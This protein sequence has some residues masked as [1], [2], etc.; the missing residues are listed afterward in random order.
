MKNRE[1]RQIIEETQKN[2]FVVRATTG[3]RTGP[4]GFIDVYNPIVEN[5]NSKILGSG[6]PILAKAFDYEVP[7]LGI[8]K[9]NFTATIYN[10]LIY[11]RG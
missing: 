5:L 11:I 4:D 3:F 9:D 2:I 7:E 10:N 6:R 1:S 8:V